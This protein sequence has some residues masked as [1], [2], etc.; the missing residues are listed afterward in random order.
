M[1]KW[2]NGVQV[3]AT[4]PGQPVPLK[5]SGLIRQTDSDPEPQAKPEENTEVK[6][7]EDNG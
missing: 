5:L 2:I 6:E 1:I 7:G 3:Q 4:A